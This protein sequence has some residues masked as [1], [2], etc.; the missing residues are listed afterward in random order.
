MWLSAQAVYG[1]EIERAM[2]VRMTMNP[3]SSTV[4]SFTTLSESANIQTDLRG[5]S[6]KAL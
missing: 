2:T 3:T 1:D 5:G 4:S 6:H